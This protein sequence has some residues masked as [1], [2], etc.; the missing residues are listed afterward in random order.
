MSSNFPEMEHSILVAS[1]NQLSSDLKDETIILH[2][3]SGTYYGLDEIGAR[4]WQLI[5]QPRTSQ[6]IREILVAEFD[7]DA[8][9]CNR[10]LLIL[11]EQLHSEDL[12]QI[13]PVVQ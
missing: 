13:Q 10:D 9:Q 1:S 12:I 2:L 8:E 7:V 3:Q 4:V 6:E 11:L 5:Q